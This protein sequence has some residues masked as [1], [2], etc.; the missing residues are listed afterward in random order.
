MEITLELVEQLRTKADVTYAQAK[1]A[2]EYSQGNLLD[3]LIYLEEQGAIPRAR[4]TYYSTQSAPGPEL[5]AEPA[6][7]PPGGTGREL[8]PKRRWNLRALLLAIRRGLLENELEVWRRQEPVTAM[9][10]L[11][12]MI[13]AVFAPWVTFPLLAVGL[14]F[15]FRYRFSGPDLERDAINSVMER[16]ATTADDVGRQVMDELYAQHEKHSRDREKK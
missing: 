6:A 14:F 1:Q 10:I 9:P 16:V 11:I 3:A 4:Q 12:L 15:G 13:L 8:K 2:L 5:P 7:P